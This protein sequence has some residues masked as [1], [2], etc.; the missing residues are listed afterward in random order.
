M[1]CLHRLS[2]PSYQINAATEGGPGRE[3][4]LCG[5]KRQLCLPAES[6]VNTR[7]A[8]EYD[9]NYITALNNR[10]TLE[11]SHD[12]FCNIITKSTL[13]KKC[14]RVWERAR[15]GNTREIKQCYLTPT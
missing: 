15:I 3:P 10:F 6:Q 13:H 8:T 4:R 9:F 12:C 2:P 5:H 7:S 11:K 14:V 1:S